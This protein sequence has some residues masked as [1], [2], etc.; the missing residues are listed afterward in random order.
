MEI[1]NERGLGAP[2]S[3]DWLILFFSDPS[4]DIHANFHLLQ[5]KIKPP[6]VQRGKSRGH[7]L[8]WTQMILAEGGH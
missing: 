7:L 6:K 3:F 1:E 2:G 5:K 4:S 8:F